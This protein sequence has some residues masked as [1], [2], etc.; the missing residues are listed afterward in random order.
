MKIKVLVGFNAR[1]KLS[2]GT[3]NG[4][5]PINPGEYT[6]KNNQDGYLEIQR[7]DGSSGFIS[8]DTF[9]KLISNSGIT[10]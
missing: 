1:R 4:F 6:A 8:L 3:I 10:L 9:E 7:Q 2:D 5:I